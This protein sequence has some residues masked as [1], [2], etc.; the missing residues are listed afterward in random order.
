MK[1]ICKVEQEVSVEFLDIKKAKSVYL[2][3]DWIY[4]FNSLNDCVTDNWI[5]GGE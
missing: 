4:K 3:K 2:S 5:E 1:I